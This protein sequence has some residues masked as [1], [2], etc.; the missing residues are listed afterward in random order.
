MYP[1]HSTPPPCP[2]RAIGWPIAPLG[3]SELCV[4]TRPPLALGDHYLAQTA[5]PEWEPS[6]GCLANLQCRRQVATATIL[7]RGEGKAQQPASFTE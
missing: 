3:A 1:T 5:A 6:Q 7:E 2:K 4:C